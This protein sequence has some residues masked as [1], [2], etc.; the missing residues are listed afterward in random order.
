MKMT[1][2]NVK[3][4]FEMEFETCWE[5][6]V[7]LKSLEVEINSSPSERSSTQLKQV[8]KTLV[9]DINATDTTSLRAA[10]NSYLRWIML[11]Y[12]ILKLKKDN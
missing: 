11:S 6:E 5:A 1:L 8:N 7:V 10:L 2:K 3:T 12:D 9:L 4:E